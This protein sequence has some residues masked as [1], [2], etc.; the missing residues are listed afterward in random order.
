MIESHLFL[1]SGHLGI[2]GQHLRGIAHTLVKEVF[3]ERK[4]VGKRIIA[5]HLVTIGRNWIMCVCVRIL[6]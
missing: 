6:F 3:L 2:N 1:R 5:G 4:E